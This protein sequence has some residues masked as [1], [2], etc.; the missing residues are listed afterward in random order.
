MKKGSLKRI[1][2]LALVFI[3][4]ALIVTSSFVVYA[5]DSYYNATQTIISKATGTLINHESATYKFKITGDSEV[6]VDFDSN[7]IGDYRIEVK[8]SDGYIEYED[9]S[10]GSS[11]FDFELS[12]GNYTL[13]ITE[14]SSYDDN[15]DEINGGEL[16]YSFTMKRSYHKTIKTTKAKLNRKKVKI[17]RF[18]SFYLYGSYSPSN[19]TQSGSWKSS[20]KKVATV[21]SSGY[22]YAKNLGTTTITYK[23]GSKKATCKVI[24]NHDTL[25][26]G[27]GKS[28]N[29][30][31]LVKYAKGYKKAK[32]S[33]SSS[34]VSVSKKGK[35]KAKK[36]GQATITAKIKGTKYKVK[37][38]SYDKK[39]LKKESKKLLKSLLVVPSSLKV[40]T[41]MYPD[42]RHCKIY[43][44]GKN[45]YGTRVYMC[46]MFYYSYGTLYTY[47]VF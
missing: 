41:V 29:L 17:C 38:Y 3:L 12:S 7:T 24:V 9:S 8:D 16:N 23:H 45:V 14:D 1:C 33:S 21:S 36:H 25:E 35:I 10:Y 43:Y 32:W 44:S 42:F 47:R 15:E 13:T 11:F 19:S 22:V 40:G 28:N 34:K 46:R 39:T 4:S 5:G 31:K 20:N 6:W 2:T 18:N 27:K 37:V 26:M 30:K